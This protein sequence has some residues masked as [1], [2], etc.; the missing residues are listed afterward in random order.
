MSGEFGSPSH[1]DEDTIVEAHQDTA[2]G[3][4]LGTKA[5]MVRVRKNANEMAD[6]ERDRFLFAMKALRNKGGSGFLMFQELHRLASTAGDEAHRQPAFFPWHRALLLHV[7]RELQAIDPSVTLPYWNWDAA[8]PNIFS[9]DFMGAPGT[10]GFF[11]AEPVFALGHPFVG[12]DTDLP[13]SG[14]ELRR[15]MNDHTRCARIRL[16]MPRRTATRSR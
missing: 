13:F 7:E 3:A 2:A 12:W 14:G 15:N 11:I 4:I 10:G 9:E 1:N 5:L 8:A 6:A 16:R